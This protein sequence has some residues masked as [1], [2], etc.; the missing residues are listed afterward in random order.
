MLKIEFSENGN[1]S[2]SAP[3]VSF[4]SKD[5]VDFELILDIINKIS[6]SWKSYVFDSSNIEIKWISYIEFV[7]DNEKKCWIFKKW[8]WYSVV[9]P[10][11]VWSGHIKT[12]VFSMI[13]VWWQIRYIDFDKNEEYDCIIEFRN[14]VSFDREKERFYL[15]KIWKINNWKY[16]NYLFRIVKNIYWWYD[17]MKTSLNWKDSVY[18]KFINFEELEKYILTNTENI[19]WIDSFSDVKYD[20]IVSH[21]KY[22]WYIFSVFLVSFLWF[23]LPNFIYYSWFE[24]IN[25][26]F[27]WWFQAFLISIAIALTIF[28]F[29][30]NVSKSLVF[31]LS[32]FIE[33]ILFFL[34]INWILWGFISIFGYLIFFAFMMFFKYFFSYLWKCFYKENYSIKAIYTAYWKYLDSSFWSKYLQF[35]MIKH[36]VYDCDGLYDLSIKSLEF[37]KKIDDRKVL[38]KSF[39][40]KKEWEKWSEI[41]KNFNLQAKDSIS[42][43]E[44]IIDNNA[45]KDA[46]VAIKFYNK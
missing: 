29:K 13:S 6:S 12:Q 3:V 21:L 14:N 16:E 23:F 46:I 34:L 26:I 8:D 19:S 27:S 30:I 20:N 40:F 10:D 15:S 18:S 24:W 38:I 9:Y 31:F 37:Y 39:S 17:L 35:N 28:I 32:F 2:F 33:I 1:D 25:L 43:I 41:R 42:E 22:I 5:R 44:E 11:F 45:I 7:C 36:F 4:C